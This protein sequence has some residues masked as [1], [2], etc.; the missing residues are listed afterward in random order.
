MVYSLIS[1]KANGYSD[2]DNYVKYNEDGLRLIKK[3]ED[4]EI[5]RVEVSWDG[6]IL[7]NDDNIKVFYADPDTGNLKYYWIYTRDGRHHR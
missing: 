7:R 3:V 2:F 1:Q 5:S 4:N 6:F